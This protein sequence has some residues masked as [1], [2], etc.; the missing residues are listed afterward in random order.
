[1]TYCEIK[2]LKRVG[3]KG[4]WTMIAINH[5]WEDY[6]PDCKR[7]QKKITCISKKKNVGAGSYSSVCVG[8]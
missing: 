5:N 2:H 7:Y 6:K 8:K 4:L 3:M 1:M